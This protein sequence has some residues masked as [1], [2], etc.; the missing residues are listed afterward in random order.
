MTR[1]IIEHYQLRN[2]S[3]WIV[4]PPQECARCGHM[5]SWFVNEYGQTWCSMC[6]PED[7]DQ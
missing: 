1:P 7:K 3:C 6:Q 2:G 4:Q 5:A